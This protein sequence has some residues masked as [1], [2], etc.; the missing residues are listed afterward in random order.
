MG[1]GIKVFVGV[2]KVYEGQP[3][4][5][6]H[7]FLIPPP[8]PHPPPFPLSLFRKRKT[9]LAYLKASIQLSICTLCLTLFLSIPYHFHPRLHITYPPSMPRTKSTNSNS[10]NSLD[11][12]ATLTRDVYR[13]RAKQITAHAPVPYGTIP[14]RRSSRKVSFGCFWMFWVGW[15]GYRWVACNDNGRIDVCC[16][17][18]ILLE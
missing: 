8:S 11:I 1:K 5:S 2:L 12:P 4:T 16:F 17:S 3:V 10:S 6:H 13:H 7:R 14:T 18:I 9:K 15:C